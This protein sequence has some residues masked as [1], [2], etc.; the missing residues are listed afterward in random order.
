MENEAGVLLRSAVQ[1]SVFVLALAAGVFVEVMESVC[2]VSAGVCAC[3]Y[4]MHLKIQEK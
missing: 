2:V 3:F 4:R 1:R